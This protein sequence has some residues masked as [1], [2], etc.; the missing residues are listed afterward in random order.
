MP[1][2][3]RVI[4]LKDFLRTDVHGVLD[5]EASKRLLAAIA[6]ECAKHDGHHVLLDMRDA[7]AEGGLPEIYEL[8]AYLGEL[9]LG[10]RNRIALL[11]HQRDTFDRA[12]FFARYAERQGLQVSA[13]Q[14]FEWALDWLQKGDV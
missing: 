7:R 10:V 14:D 8:V 12:Q 2:D 13:F 6:S 3:I 5:M 4:S 9:G 1:H 11:Y